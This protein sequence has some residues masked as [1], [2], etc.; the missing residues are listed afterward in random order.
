MQ[1][2]QGREWYMTGEDLD[3]AKVTTGWN[4]KLE[5]ALTRGYAGLRLSADTAWLEKRDWKEFCDYENEVNH[6]IDG[7]PMI[8]LCSYPLIGSAAAEILD[9]TRTHQFAIARRNKRWEVIETSE[10]KQAKR[11]IQRLNDELE[12]RVV[13][14]TRQVINA[15]EELKWQISERQRAEGALSAARAELAHATRVTVMGEMVASIAHEVTQPL[16]GIITNG[17]ACLNWLRGSAPN[18]EKAQGAAERIIRDGERANEVIREI[19]TLVKKTPPQKIPLDINDLIRRTIALTASELASNHVEVETD[20]VSGISE[21]F[22]DRVQLQQVLLNLIVNAIEAMGTV[23]DRPRRLVIR[24]EPRKKPSGVIVT[25]QDSGVGLDLNER[26]RVFDA[27]FTTKPQ[28]LG[29]GLSIC[30]TIILDHGGRLSAR[31]NAGHGATFEF[32][33]PARADEIESIGAN[34]GRVVA[35]AV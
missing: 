21:V 1:I 8:A 16:T 20:L 11:E 30:Q 17:N 4:Q 5:L 15:N 28:G 26:D 6:S 32:T 24:S 29:M 25:V 12:Q 9:V 27:F 34:G 18:M 31:S 23:R 35:A 14:R 33:V 22:G 3:L 10:L 2:V 13:E 19:R 7:Q